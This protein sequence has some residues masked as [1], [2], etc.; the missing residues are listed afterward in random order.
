MTIIVTIVDDEWDNPPHHYYVAK[1]DKN[2]FDQV[3]KAISKVIWEDL[4]NEDEI[5]NDEI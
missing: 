1:I 3:E 4:Q 2:N 5:I